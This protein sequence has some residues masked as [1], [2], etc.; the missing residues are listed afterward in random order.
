MHDHLAGE[1]EERCS[2]CKCCGHPPLKI[3]AQSSTCPFRTSH[4]ATCA[5]KSHQA[6]NTETS[7]TIRSQGREGSTSTSQET[8]H[9]EL[10]SGQT[11]QQSSEQSPCRLKDLQDHRDRQSYIAEN[12]SPRKDLN[13]KEWVEPHGQNAAKGASTKRERENAANQR[14]ASTKRPTSTE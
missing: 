10:G 11:H 14:A 1:V 12:P 6:R 2:C 7:T 4:R 9:P 13:S 3:R 8:Q 5:E